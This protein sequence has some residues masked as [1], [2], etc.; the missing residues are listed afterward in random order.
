MNLLKVKT[1]VNFIRLW[2]RTSLILG[3]IE[4]YRVVRAGPLE[5]G[6]GGQGG[7]LIHPPSHPNPPKHTHILLKIVKNE[8]FMGTF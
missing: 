4:F 7:Q 3:P 2:L 5:A 8:S 1:K 6:G